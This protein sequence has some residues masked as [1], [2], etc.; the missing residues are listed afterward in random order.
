[1]RGN[2]SLS[3]G[4]TLSKKEL[5]KISDYLPPAKLLIPSRKQ[6]AIFL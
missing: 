3:A 1:M 4:F 2:S 6:T 5:R